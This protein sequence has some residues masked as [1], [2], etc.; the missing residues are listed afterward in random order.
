MESDGQ[1][2][3]P[4][5]TLPTMLSQDGF[6]CINSS[7]VSIQNNSYSDFS[8]ILPDLFK[9]NNDLYIDPNLVI[10]LTEDNIKQEPLELSSEVTEKSL[11]LLPEWMS[12]ERHERYGPELSCSR[13]FCK[14]KRKEHY[15]CNACNQVSKTF[16]FILFPLS[17]FGR[18]T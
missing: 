17:K 2:V 13:P 10:N 12:I 6:K 18:F 7:S 15:H 1:V 14:L 8:N 16:Y 4:T 9:R 11:H 3:Q 5:P